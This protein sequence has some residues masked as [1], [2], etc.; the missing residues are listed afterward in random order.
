MVTLNW[1]I[2][3]KGDHLTIFNLIN[4]ISYFI[5]NN[6]IINFAEVDKEGRWMFGLFWTLPKP[7]KKNKSILAVVVHIY[8]VSTTYFKVK[9]KNTVTDQFTLDFAPPHRPSS[10]QSFSPYI[11]HDKGSCLVLPHLCGGLPLFK[12]DD[13]HL[14]ALLCHISCRSLKFLESH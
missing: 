13:L 14:A 2:N 4:W 3:S 7:P 6:D 11:G 10:A 8:S 5:L 1:P 9:F 12:Q